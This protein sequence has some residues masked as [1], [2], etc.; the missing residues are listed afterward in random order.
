MRALAVPAA[1]P[2]VQCGATATTRKEPSLLGVKLT[3][4]VRLST[5][6]ALTLRPPAVT[7]A[8]APKVPPPAPGLV[9]SFQVWAS[10]PTAPAVCALGDRPDHSCT[11]AVCA[12]PGGA[13]VTSTTSSSLS[14]RR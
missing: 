12:V 3:R 2:P 6:D 13:P 7:A 10:S 9:S 5:M 14:A 11:C 8:R 4:T 1:S